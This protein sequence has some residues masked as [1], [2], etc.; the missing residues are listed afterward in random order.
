MAVSYSFANLFQEGHECS[1]VNRMLDIKQY[2]SA[3]FMAH[4]I[5]YALTGELPEQMTA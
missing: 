4:R 5:R 1:P 3:W 2:K